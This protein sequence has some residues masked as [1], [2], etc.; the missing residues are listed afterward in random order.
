MWLSSS[1]HL[2]AWVL[3]RCS[4][5]SAMTRTA[6]PR[7]QC[8]PRSA[9]SRV[10]TSSSTGMTWAGTRTGWSVNGSVLVRILL[11]LACVQ[12]VLTLYPSSHGSRPDLVHD[13]VTHPRLALTPPPRLPRPCLSRVRS[14]PVGGSCH[15]VD[16]LTAQAARGHPGTL[17]AS[18]RDRVSGRVP[19][20]VESRP[21]RD[22]VGPPRTGPRGSSRVTIRPVGGT[23]SRPLTFPHKREGP[24]GTLARR[25]GS[26]D[27]SLLSARNEQTAP[28][29]TTRR[30]AKRCVAWGDGQRVMPIAPT[31]FR[32]NRVGAPACT[33]RLRPFRT[34]PAAFDG[35]VQ[36]RVPSR[37]ESAW[38]PHAPRAWVP[39]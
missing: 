6:S 26:D 28:H 14:R 17:R 24:P 36:H 8:P 19:L 3:C 23:R 30:A 20:R 5:S 21:L 33:G 31:A 34:S 9:F 25:C 37:D 22:R 18:V 10:F 35:R 2:C 1:C 39:A 7:P 4:Q 32:E 29:H 13:R 27:S 16:S 12:T 38:L 15:R 11:A